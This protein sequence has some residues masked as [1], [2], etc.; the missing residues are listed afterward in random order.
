MSRE[1]CECKL[2]AGANYNIGQFKLRHPEVYSLSDAGR[3][4]WGKLGGEVLGVIFSLYMSVY[5]LS[6]Q[7]M[8]GSSSR[9]VPLSPSASP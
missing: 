4:M 8:A 3:I 9:P 7:L 2:T 5:P 1:L 6:P